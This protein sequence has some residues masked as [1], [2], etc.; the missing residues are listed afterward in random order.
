M[1]ATSYDYELSPGDHTD[2]DDNPICCDTDMT[3]KDTSG[4][5][6][7]TCDTCQTVISISSSGLVS[8]INP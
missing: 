4:G 1:P 5:R 3:G 6:D 8:S 7:Y 2:P